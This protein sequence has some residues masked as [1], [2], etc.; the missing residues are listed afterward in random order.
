MLDEPGSRVIVGAAPGQR[1]L[2]NEDFGRTITQLRVRRQNRQAANAFV[3]VIEPY[4]SRPL[5][6]SVERIKTREGAAAVKVVTDRGTDY[7]VSSMDE[8]PVQLRDG[9]TTVRVAGRFGAVSLDKT[10]T[11]RWL[12]VARGRL[13]RVGDF[14][15]RIDGPSCLAGTV[16]EMQPRDF[17]LVVRAD[18]P[19]PRGNALAG[20]TLIVQHTRGRSSFTIDRVEPA[21]E[22]TQRVVFAGMPKLLENVL[23]VS[24]VEP[25]RIVVEP[26]PVLG[27]SP[28]DYHVYH[29]RKGGLRPLGKLKGRRRIGILDERGRRLHYFTALNVANTEGVSKGDE[30]AISRIVPGRDTFEIPMSA[31]MGE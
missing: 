11:P 6:R 12:L 26:P 20:R 8:E 1:L 27:R 25:T 18:P 3:A 22:G 2:R 10:G 15:V 19:L 28:V 9:D 31:F 17:A 13:A 30:V 14:D 16:V 21:T 29:L 5:I 24:D 23:L 4:R 7:V